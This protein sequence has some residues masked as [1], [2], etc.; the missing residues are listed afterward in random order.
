MNRD[1]DSLQNSEQ[2]LEKLQKQLE[3]AKQAEDAAKSEKQNLEKMLQDSKCEM[4]SL[5]SAYSESDVTHYKEEIKSLKTQLELTQAAFKNTCYLAPP[6][7]Q[8]WLQLTY[9]LEQKSYDKKKMSAEKQLQ[10]AREAKHDR[11]N[12]FSVRMNSVDDLDMNDDAGS[13]YG[14]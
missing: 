8:Q 2:A 4:T 12:G 5:T 14:L 1:M 10:Q 7:L 3:E 13:V 9:E 6:G 11:F